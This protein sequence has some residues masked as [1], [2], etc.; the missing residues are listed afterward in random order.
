MRLFVDTSAWIA[1]EDRDDSHHDEAAQFWEEVR[2][3]RTE[4]RQIFTPNYVVDEVMTLLARRVSKHSAEEFWREMR[5][6][7]VVQTLRVAE[8]IEVKAFDIF[9]GGPADLSFTDSTSSAP[10]KEEA[11]DSCFGFDRQFSDFGFKVVSA[12]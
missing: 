6:T 11:I 1:L 12:R 4:F 10:M 3:G 7:K 5:K 8:E 2:S 9:I